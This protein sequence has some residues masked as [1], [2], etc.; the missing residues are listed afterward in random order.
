MSYPSILLV[1]HG[2]R[3]DE[4]VAQFL[5]FAASLSERLVQPVGH[6]FLELADPDMATGLSDAAR[7]AGSSGKV[8]VVPIFLG[9]AGHEKNDVASAIQWGRVQFPDVDF[10]YGAPLGLHARLVELLDIRV[11]GAIEA[12]PQVLP[13]DDTCVLVVGRGSSDPDS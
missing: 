3:R 12:D 7:R 8:V 10:R 11:H 13:L 1:G 6:C 9:S 4:A 5:E 2:S